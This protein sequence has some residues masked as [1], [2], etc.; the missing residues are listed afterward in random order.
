MSFLESRGIVLKNF[1]QNVDGLD[2]KAG[3]SNVAFCHGNAQEA[4]CIDCDSHVDMEKMNKAIKDKKTLRCDVCNGLCK[5]KIVLYGEQLDKKVISSFDL[6]SKADLCLIMGTSLKVSPFN[7]LPNLV[8]NN[9]FVV[10]INN[11]SVG[12]FNFE[13]LNSNHI[14]IKGY[15]DDCIEKIIKEIKL[16]KEFNEFIEDKKALK[17]K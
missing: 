5:P 13:D 16:E 3:C 4:H 8:N 1:T 11:E 12:D 14:L 17:T 7:T 6:L 15:T 2:I 9:C 10:V